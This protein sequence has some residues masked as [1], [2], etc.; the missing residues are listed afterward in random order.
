MALGGDSSRQ[1]KA[2]VRNIYSLASEMAAFANSKGGT[3]LIGV[4]DDGYMPVLSRDDVSRV[5]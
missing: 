2:Y 4:A 3:I 5:S 1:F